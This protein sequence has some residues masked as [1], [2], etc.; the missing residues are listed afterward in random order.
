MTAYRRQTN[1]GYNFTLSCPRTR[2]SPHYARGQI[3]TTPANNGSRQRQIVLPPAGLAPT[4]ANR[5]PVTAPHVTTGVCSQQQLYTEQR[6]RCYSGIRHHRRLQSATGLHL[7]T[8]VPL[9]RHK[10]PQVSAVSNRLTF[11][12]RRPV[13]APYVTTGVCSQQQAY[14]C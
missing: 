14:T 2:Y 10:S 5:R 11:V 12:N 7:L 6:V 13:I 9:Q 3:G 8:G 4:S 1:P